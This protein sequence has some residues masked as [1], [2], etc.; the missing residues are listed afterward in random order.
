MI[1]LIR[2]HSGLLLLGNSLVN[3]SMAGPEELQGV[4][5]VSKEME[6]FVLEKECGHRD[7]QKRNFKLTTVSAMS[8][9]KEKALLTDFLPII[10]ST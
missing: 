10:F 4:C 5:W 9:L 7:E 8:Q 3:H 6:L 2:S 1:V